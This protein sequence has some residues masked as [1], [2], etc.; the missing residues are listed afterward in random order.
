LTAASYKNLFATAL[1]GGD[2]SAAVDN[3]MQV[4][5]SLS[6]DL[7]L[8]RRCI[9]SFTAFLSS[10]K[11]NPTPAEIEGIKQKALANSA[12]TV[13]FITSQPGLKKALTD[14][15]MKAN[16][17]NREFYQQFSEKETY[18]PLFLENP[19][20]PYDLFSTLGDAMAAKIAHYEQ[21]IEI[22]VREN[23]LGNLKFSYSRRLFLR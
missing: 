19:T 7:V 11:S 23:K 12:D 9:T 18:E 14:P 13:L 10:L 3:Y 16:P 15:A 5:T 8:T 21:V 6:S 20:I 1:A 22:F 4:V 17:K 2:T